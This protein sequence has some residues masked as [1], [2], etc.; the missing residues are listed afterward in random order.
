VERKKF[1]VSFP[2]HK[3]N[4]CA[5]SKDKKRSG[6]AESAHEARMGYGGKK[7]ELFSAQ[8]QR[9]GK[10]KPAISLFE[11]KRDLVLGSFLRFTAIWPEPFKGKK[12][13]RIFLS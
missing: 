12:E 3:G 4:F 9:E 5:C 6:C 13:G 10:G 1:H 11:Q 7:N 2:R 8:E